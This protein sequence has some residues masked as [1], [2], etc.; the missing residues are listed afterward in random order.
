MGQNDQACSIRI[1]LK[2]YVIIFVNDL[3]YVITNTCSLYNYADDNTLGFCHPDINIF[4]TKLEEGP[5]IALN[6]PDENHVKANISKFQSIALRLKGVIDD[7]SFCVSDYT[8]QPVCCVN[9][10]GHAT[11]LRQHDVADVVLT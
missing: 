7:I 3:I 9:T 1:G 10:S 4:K 5:K 8:L 2:S 11:R 6:W